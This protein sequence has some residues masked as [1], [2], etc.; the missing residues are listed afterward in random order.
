[1]SIDNDLDI[2]ENV[3]AD[4]NDTSFINERIHCNTINVLDDRVSVVISYYN[5]LKCLKRT[6]DGLKNQTF[7][8]KHIEVLIC[9][10]GS[11][12]LVE[13][14]DVMDS[15]ASIFMDIQHHWIPK[16]GFGLSKI[17]NIGMNRSKYNNI[18]LLDC[19]MIPLPD[20][21]ENHVLALKACI[22]VV[23]IG[24]RHHMTI[25]DQIETEGFTRGMSA[26]SFAL[27]DLDWRLNGQ[28]VD[29]INY[30]SKYDSYWTWAQASGGNLAFNRIVVDK[31]LMFDESFNEWG[32]EDNEWAYRLFKK[33]FYFY[34]NLR[35]IAIHQDKIN[36]KNKIT[37]KKL[38]HLMKKCP[39]IQDAYKNLCYSPSDTPLIS[40]WMCN[41]N[42]GKYIEQAIK[43][44]LCCPYRFEIVIV[45]D[46]SVDESVEI[47]ESMQVPQVRLIKKTKGTLGEAFKL[48]LDSCRGEVFI[49]LDS[50]DFISDMGKLTDLMIYALF[51]SFGLV[52]GHHFMVNEQGYFLNNGWVHPECNRNKSLFE[53]MHIHPPR[54]IQSRFYA[55]S[56]VINTKLDTAV[57]YDLYSKILEVCNGR[58]YFLDCYAYRQHSNS[59]SFNFENSQKQ[60]VAEIIKERL[61]YYNVYDIYSLDSTVPRHCIVSRN[62]NNKLNIENFMTKG[63]L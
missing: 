26:D 38:E 3:F 43:S 40:F 58:F 54:L 15:Y 36:N 18:I 29:D 6:L 32:G 39:R 44:V 50:D 17:R 59:V 23:S 9:D 12:P 62:G 21:I 53:G 8:C 16:D 56:R 22:G 27:S 51:G 5:D 63:D 11:D 7:P 1:M 20:M 35:A 45:D 30:K 13:F 31:D 2:C 10:D 25:D 55:R 52:Y 46:G 4:L 14:Q 33:G 41:N 49:Q 28:S 61:I 47:I 19:D 57:D 42:R 37:A 60:N 24:F 48:A 34:P